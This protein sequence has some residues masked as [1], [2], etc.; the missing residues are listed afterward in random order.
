MKLVLMLKYYF[1]EYKKNIFLFGIILVSL[2]FSFFYFSD[3]EENVGKRILKNEI[4][5]ENIFNEN[6]SNKEKLIIKKEENKVILTEK[7]IAKE[8]IDKEPKKTILYSTTSKNNH[9][10]IK[11]ISNKKIEKKE[12][13]PKYIV[14]TG[15][16]TDGYEE[17]DFPMSIN[18]NYLEDTSL[19]FFEIKDNQKNLKSICEAYFLDSLSF[20]FSYHMKVEFIEELSDCYI[21]SQS[22]FIEEESFS[23]EKEYV[24]IKGKSM[25]VLADKQ[26]NIKNKEEINKLKINEILE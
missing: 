18:D 3:K 13:A 14:L 9:Y 5:S 6:E 24:T 23:Q 2:I 16:I 19:L 10:S 26:L 21:L 7:K 1:K 20:G 11:L 25:G 17:S 15:T 8:V 4:S 22:D 12:L